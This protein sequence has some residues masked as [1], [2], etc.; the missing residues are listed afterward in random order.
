MAVANETFSNGIRIMQLY[1]RVAE[2]NYIVSFRMLKLLE[3]GDVDKLDELINQIA[4]LC[5]DHFEDEKP[6]EEDVQKIQEL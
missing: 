5:T 4:A 2:T 1:Q 3:E 6:T